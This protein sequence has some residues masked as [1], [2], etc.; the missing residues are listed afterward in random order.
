[1]KFLHSQVIGF[2]DSWPAK[3]IWPVDMAGFAINLQYLKQNASMPY[4]AG[5]EEDR[6]LRNNNI[7]L[8]DIEPKAN[9]CTEILVW[10]TQTRRKNV[11]KLL[12]N[13]KSMESNPLHFNLALL[14]REVTHQGMGVLTSSKGAT[15]HITKDGQTK[16]L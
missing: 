16:S 9:N 1:M 11:A 4:K 8:E 15:P 10:H 12:M 6:F 7:T 2:F 13:I 3:R 14:I 5:F